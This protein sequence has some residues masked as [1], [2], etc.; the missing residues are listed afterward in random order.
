MKILFL[1]LLS[2]AIIGLMVPSVSAESIPNWI[3]NTAGW[4]ATDAIKENDFVNAIQWLIKMGIMSVSS[5]AV[6]DDMSAPSQYQSSTPTQPKQSKSTGDASLDEM[7]LQ[8]QDK[9]NK[10]EIRDC[11]KV[12]KEEYKVNQYKSDADAFVVSGQSICL[13]ICGMYVA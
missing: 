13:Q 7:L 3:K 4:W 2:V 12:I 5:S 8:C 6:G 1:F 9:P 11:E 10:R